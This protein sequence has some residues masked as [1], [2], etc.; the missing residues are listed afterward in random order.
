MPLYRRP[1]SLIWYYD[2]RR[3]GRS[4]IRRSTHT[5]DREAAQRQHD[6]AAARAW[7]ER[8]GGK[9]LTDALAAWLA[10]RERS[11]PELSALAQIRAKYADRPL[12]DVTGESVADTFAY[13]SAPTY[14]RTVTII[15]AALNI[16]VARGWREAAPKIP[17]RKV[18]RRSFRWLT[19]EEWGKLRQALPEHLQPMADFAIAT[20]LRWGD[21]A[22]M[23]WERV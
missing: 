18:A 1:G 11:R 6:E 5:S 17:R 20:G 19:P 3:A 7:K 4:R 15:R 21:V 8:E 10:A 22:G 12:R 14:N 23:S 13:L 16:A 2:V 9:R